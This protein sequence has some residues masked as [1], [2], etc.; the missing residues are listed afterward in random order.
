MLRICIAYKEYCVQSRLPFFLDEQC[1]DIV[2]KVIMVGFQ[3]QGKA[4][5]FYVSFFFAMWKSVSAMS[6]T[7]GFLMALLHFW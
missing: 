2:D 3:V 1:I 6:N 5:R 7:S 4:L